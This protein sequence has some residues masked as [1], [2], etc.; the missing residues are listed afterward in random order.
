M[1]KMARRVF[2]SFDYDTDIWRVNQVRHSWVTQGEDAGYIDA[3]DFEKIRRQG[4]DAIERWIDKQLEGTSVTVVLIG[5]KTSESKWVRYE[6][7]KSWERGNGLIGI[8]IHNLRDQDGRTDIKGEDPFV[9]LGYQGIRT[10]DWLIDKGY[11][12][13]GDWI[14][15][16]Y[17]RAQNRQKQ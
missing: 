9:K 17:K 2:F 7:N 4:E 13:L 12:N 8:Y 15:A 1:F 5:A 14:E 6:I 16:A 11:E 10:Y 3:A